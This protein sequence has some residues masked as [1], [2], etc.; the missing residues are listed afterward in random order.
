MAVCVDLLTFQPCSGM[1]FLVVL[2]WGTGPGCVLVRTACRC[3]IWG[4]HPVEW[5]EE[6]WFG[7]TLDDASLA[8][9]RGWLAWQSEHI[10]GRDR[11]AAADGVSWEVLGSAAPTTHRMLLLCMDAAWILCC[12]TEAMDLSCVELSVSSGGVVD[13]AEAPVQQLCGCCG[14]MLFRT[15]VLCCCSC[16]LCRCLKLDTCFPVTSVDFQC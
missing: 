6:V 1:C 7:S 15:A 14:V 9:F 8:S 2:W 4:R 5:V 12:L 11:S 3:W 13:A 16:V 10:K